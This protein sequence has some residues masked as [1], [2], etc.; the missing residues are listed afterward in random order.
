MPKFKSTYAVK[1]NTT[2]QS[3]ISFYITYYYLINVNC[4]NF[5]KVYR[6]VFKSCTSNIVNA[7]L[8]TESIAM[9]DI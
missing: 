4:T 9:C 1:Y 6:T 8:V 2:Q 5:N 3:L 7:H